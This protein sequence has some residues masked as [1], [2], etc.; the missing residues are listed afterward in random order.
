MKIEQ[1]VVE[2]QPVVITLEAMAEVKCLL[3]AIDYRID[4]I[5]GNPEYVSEE[6]FLIEL[7]NFLEDVK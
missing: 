5:T 4:T 3:E 2:F 6:V 7:S 1:E